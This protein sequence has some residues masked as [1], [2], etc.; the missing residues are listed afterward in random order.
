MQKLSF[1]VMVLSMRL[2]ELL[3]MVNSVIRVKGF[4]LKVILEVLYTT[5]DTS[6]LGMKNL[7]VKVHP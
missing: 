1:S 4:V 2:L 5:L 3:K 7:M 6:L